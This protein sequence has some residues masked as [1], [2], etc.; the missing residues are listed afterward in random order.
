M[1]ALK[2]GSTMAEALGVDTFR[3]KVIAFVYA[4]LLAQRLGLALRALPAHRQPDAV[5]H[6]H[7]HRVPVHGGGRRRRPRLGRGRR[8]RRRHDPEGPAA[9][10]LP[11]LLG[12]S[13]NFE[14]I[15][16]G[17]LLV[18]VLQYARDGVCGRSSTRCCRA[19]RRKV[20]WAD[21]R[22]AAGAARAARTARSLLDVQRGAQGVRRPGRGQRRQL[23]GQG[24]RDPRPDRPERRRQV[25]H[26]Q[27]VTG[28]LPLTR[29]EVAL[30]R[31]A[32]RSA[33][34]RARSRAAASRAPSST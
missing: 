9:G 33:R 14:I 20:D 15:V 12:T 13:G 5:R 7:G 3:V 24:R 22:A 11:K 8:R 19:L 18:L 27:P 30:A 32:H 4:A 28:V 16:F 25:H 6:Q 34:R 26:L 1:R 17:V 23:R 29:G 31:P 10:L 21:A 2:G